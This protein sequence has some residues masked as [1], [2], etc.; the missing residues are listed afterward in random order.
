MELNN[1]MD[2]CG[3]HASLTIPYLYPAVERVI[4]N[5]KGC[6]PRPDRPL[7]NLPPIAS[8]SQRM[9]SHI[10][11]TRHHPLSLASLSL[12]SHATANALHYMLSLPR[13]RFL[14]A[15]SCQLSFSNPAICSSAKDRPGGHPGGNPGDHPGNHP[16]GQHG[17]HPGGHPGGNPGDNP[18]DHPG[19]GYHPGNHP[20]N[21]PWTIL[22]CLSPTSV[23]MQ[24]ALTLTSEAC[25]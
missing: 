7:R 9:P 15:H 22:V 5:S 8:Q 20:G 25:V 14:L 10:K 13:S 11:I 24:D 19:G 21:H 3:R 6:I 12:L 18:G 17:E 2:T 23:L 16:G 1:A 4:R